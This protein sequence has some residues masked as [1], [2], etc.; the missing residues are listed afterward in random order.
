MGGSGGPER[1]P[2]DASGSGGA[3]RGSSDGG[4][5]TPADAGKLTLAGE[6]FQPRSRRDAEER[7]VRM[8]M[9]GVDLVGT[10]GTVTVGLGG[11]LDL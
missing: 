2:T 9:Q 1:E 11:L 5:G 10:T 6:P 7:G 8:V 4:T 3:E